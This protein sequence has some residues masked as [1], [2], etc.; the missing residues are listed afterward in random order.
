M[1]GDAQGCHP[2]PRPSYSHTGA[3][4]RVVP[5]E[6]LR[7]LTT[8]CSAVALSWKLLIISEEGPS[9]FVLHR[10]LNY[11]A[12]ARICSPYSESKGRWGTSVQLLPAG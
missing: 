7:R 12:W 3:Y 11:V 1:V 8:N 6:M 2:Y 4:F 10:A 5:S 9:V